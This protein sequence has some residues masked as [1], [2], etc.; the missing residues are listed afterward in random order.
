M[1]EAMTS[2]MLAYISVQFL[3]VCLV[4]VAQRIGLVERP[5]GRKKHDGC[6]PLVGGISIYLGMLGADLLLGMVSPVLTAVFWVC[7]GIVLM[8]SLD[9]RYNLSALL[10]LIVQVVAASV[11]VVW[12]DVPIK[13]IGH[14]PFVGL[15]EFGIYGYLLAILLLVAITNAINMLDGID[16]LVGGLMA[17]SFLAMGTSFAAIQRQSMVLFCWSVVGAIAAFLIFNLW[18]HNQKPLR[19]IFM[20]DAGSMFLGLCMGILLLDGSQGELVAFNSATL[21]WFVLFPITDMCATLYGRFERGRSPLRP[22]RT[23]IHHRLQQAGLTKKQTLMVV[24][25]NQAVFI[26]VGLYQA[27]AGWPQWVSLLLALSLVLIY[28]PLRYQCCLYLRWYIRSS[29]LPWWLLGALK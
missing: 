8:G 1:Y 5:G 16:G 24:F 9:D 29:P 7:G 15:V 6:I 17:L 4:P 21:L 22:D 25:V 14:V 20:G 13:D 26:C 18:G 2:L 10:R 23:H 28:Y 3:V 19:K 12:V 11:L 27:I